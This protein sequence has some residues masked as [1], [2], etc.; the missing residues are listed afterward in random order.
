MLKVILPVLVILAIGLVFVVVIGLTSRASRKD[1]E[2]Y[3]APE[4]AHELINRAA[5][6]LGNLGPS[7]SIDDSDIITEK[8]RNMISTWQRDY[9]KAREKKNK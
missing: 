9:H 3:L 7:D 8:H 4:E 5:F 1:K 6:I 2:L